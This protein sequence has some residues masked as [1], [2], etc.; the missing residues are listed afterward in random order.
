VFVL[1]DPTFQLTVA[2]IRHFLDKAVSR[3]ARFL[4]PNIERSWYLHE[5]QDTMQVNAEE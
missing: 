5:V 1:L 3:I 4:W 2:L